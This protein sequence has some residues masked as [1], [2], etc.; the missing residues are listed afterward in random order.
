MKNM[1]LILLL[2]CAQLTTSGCSDDS[3]GNSF[4]H[5]FDRGSAKPKAQAGKT[6]LAELE[7]NGVGTWKIKLKSDLDFANADRE[8]FTNMEGTRYETKMVRYAYAFDSQRRL[9]GPEV[10]SASSYCAVFIDT[11]ARAQ[12]TDMNFAAQEKLLKGQLETTSHNGDMAFALQLQ[13]ARFRSFFLSCKN[14]TTAE[15]IDAHI[16]HLIHID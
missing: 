15:Q 13:G 10:Q 1:P 16:G 11:D 6:K 3:G 14:V 5:T 4:T 2:L 8:E 12:N 9:T 7:A